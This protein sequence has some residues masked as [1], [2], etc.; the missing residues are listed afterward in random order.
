MEEL[1]MTYEQAVAFLKKYME[2]NGRKQVEV[3][4]E[5]GVSGGLVSSFLAGTY[6][7]PHAIIPKV[8][9]LAKI[10]EKKAVTPKEPDFVETSV[11]RTVT[12]AIAYAH[13]RG[14]TFAVR[15][16][17]KRNSLA[18]GITISPTYASVTGVNE[19]IAEQ[20]GVRERGDRKITREIVAKL[21]NSGRVL[22]I[23]EAQHLTVRALNHLR[24][25]SDESGIGIA[26]VGNEEIYSKLRG[27]GKADFAQLF[28]RVGMRKQVLTNSLTAEDIRNIFGPYG[29][30]EGAL[31]LLSGIA[32]TNYG[33]RGAVNV[34]VNTAAV[35]GKIDK[36][37]IVKVM[38]DMNIGA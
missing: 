16:Y 5:L 25:V 26:L 24:C 14:K 32:H 12:N 7:T 34:F 20:L 9:E 19:L 33:L 37:G 18:L 8:Q 6:K 27:S 30:D 29:L 36:A 35:Y 17:M 28:S 15:E 1:T 11:S 13:L 3:A 2:E 38:R 10:H 31:G 4:A 21:R 23:D 22:V